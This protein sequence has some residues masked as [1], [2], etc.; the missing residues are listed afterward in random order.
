MD[1]PT[2]LGCRVKTNLTLESAIH[3][4]VKRMN[5]GRSLVILYL[6]LYY[7]FP[8]IGNAIFEER[9][10]TIYKITPIDL[11]MIA[12]LISIVILF[13]IINQLPSVKILP[14][15]YRDC[16]ISVFY[17]IG[18]M[19][20]RMRF[21]VSII[22]IP[23]SAVYLIAGFNSYRYSHDGISGDGS[24]YNSFIIIFN[25]VISLD[26]F[27]QIYV[28]CKSMPQ[29]DKRFKWRMA[30]GLFSL[31]LLMT[32]NGTAS[33][34]IAVFALLFSLFPGNFERLLFLGEKESFLLRSK[35]LI[36]IITMG[37]LVSLCAWFAG[38]TIKSSSTEKSG[39]IL[40]SANLMVKYI[41]ESPELIENFGYY[42]ISA[43][44]S[45]YYSMT[46]A[47][48]VK[49]VDVNSKAS[50]RL[51][52]PLQSFIYRFDIMAGGILNV[53]RPEFGSLSRLNYVLLSDEV[54]ISERQG[55]SP[56]LIASFFYVFPPVIGIFICAFYMAWV[57][58]LTN[59][60]LFHARSKSISIF[61]LLLLLQFMLMFFQ[62]PFDLLA[63]F[64][65]AY[66]AVVILFVMS[67]LQVYKRRRAPRF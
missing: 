62:S 10:F 40:S 6:I 7:V 27:Y 63:I 16:I 24:L 11:Y 36:K 18:V 12:A 9:I 30:N 33:M 32:A 3:I 50:L 42:L 2:V 23:F 45:H 64:D 4:N 31:S 20:T 46:Y 5:Y 60:L 44:S 59:N 54:A 29:W 58:R 28:Q 41:E 49:S 21:Y 56:G 35:K 53:E 34:L 48:E 57:A 47:L 1:M 55:T 67:S 13:L 8:I 66:L 43:M 14:D 52:H 37:F 39:N 19:Y 65:N 25:L 22:S 26:I 51:V 61:G 17:S 38:E 15:I